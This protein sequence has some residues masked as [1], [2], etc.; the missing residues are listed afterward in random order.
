MNYLFLIP[1]RGGSKGIPYKNIKLL[2]GKPLISYSIDIARSIAMDIDICVS[3]DDFKIKDVVESYSSL[4]VPFIRPDFLS[5]DTASTYDVIMHALSFYELQGRFYDAVVLLQP[6]SPLRMVSQVKESMSLFTKDI[7]MVVSV[8]KSHSVSVLCK[9]KQDGFLDFI[10]NNNAG[11][12][13][14]FCDYYEYNGAIYVINV[15]SLKE[16]T[17]AEFTRKQKYVMDEITSIDI[18]TPLDWVI[19]ETI[20]NNKL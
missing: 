10:F 9:E 18:D 4:H 11:R 7:D 13:Q 14:D 2:S 3:T 5:T 16:K 6:T 17:I 1:A 19:T 8:K 15:D 12:R 20:L